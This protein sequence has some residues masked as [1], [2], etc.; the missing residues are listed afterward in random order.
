[1]NIYTH[2]LPAHSNVPY[3]PL[4]L[5]ELL[6]TYLARYR[7]TGL[8]LDQLQHL[9]A[10]SNNNTGD[11]SDRIRTNIKHL[12][13]SHSIGSSISCDELDRSFAFTSLTHLCLANPGTKTSWSSLLILSRNQPHLTHLS[14][15]YWPMASPS[16]EDDDRVSATLQS[17]SRLSSTL[18]KLQYL[19][20]EGCSE[21]ISILLSDRNHRV[22]WS[23]GWKHVRCL[24]LSQGP[25]PIAISLEGGQPMENWIQGEVLARQIGDD[26][27][28]VRKYVGKLDVP[29]IRLEQGWSPDNFMIKFLVDRAYERS[30]VE[31]S[32]HATAT[33]APT[34]QFRDPEL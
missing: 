4:H 5:K 24:N 30:R 29:P 16:P 32:S 14:L 8:T 27:N 33:D 15:A 19:D 25:M 28:N 1:M 20:L 3:L 6:L 9:L 23:G 21:W 26:I 10:E 12:D 7:L 18:T 17:L 31:G 2:P 13:L 11:P 22:D 34:V